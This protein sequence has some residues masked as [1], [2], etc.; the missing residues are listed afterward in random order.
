MLRL[1]WN[2]NEHIVVESVVDETVV[3][4]LVIEESGDAKNKV[5][6]VKLDE[7]TGATK[8]LFHVGAVG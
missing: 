5:V 4:T 7:Q 8:V 6:H 2:E 1:S 3:A